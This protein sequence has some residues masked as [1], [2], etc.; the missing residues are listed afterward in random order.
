MQICDN[1]SQLAKIF[2]LDDEVIGFDSIDE[3]IEKAAYYLT[4]EDE[5][6]AVAAKGWSRAVRHYN[7]VECFGRM[8]KAVEKFKANSPTKKITLT[9]SFDRDSQNSLGNNIL[10]NA[11]LMRSKLAN[12]TN[13]RMN[14]RG[15]PSDDTTN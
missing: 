14:I 15:L 8:V 6:R 7:E 9:P 1:K 3:A 4:H 5:R 2:K 12:G 10:K 11:A 13:N